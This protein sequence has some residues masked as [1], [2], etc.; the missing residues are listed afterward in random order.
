MLGFGRRSRL[1][2]R[3]VGPLATSP[4]SRGSL[5]FSRSTQNAVEDLFGNSV[6]LVFVNKPGLAVGIRAPQAEAI[7]ICLSRN[8]SRG[9]A[10]AYGL[11]L[12][13][14]C[15]MSEEVP[16]KRSPPRQDSKVVTFQSCDPPQAFWSL[17][18]QAIYLSAM[19]S[20]EFPPPSVGHLQTLHRWP[21]GWGGR[22]HDSG[23][24]HST[25]DF[26][27]CKDRVT[28][29]RLRTLEEWLCYKRSL[30]SHCAQS[31]AHFWV[32]RYQE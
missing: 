8:G 31:L 22:Y 1:G 18:I 7:P 28:S 14:C 32:I 2:R 26:L 27:L 17:S 23:I 24:R 12:T 9:L 11:S 29:P 20:S 5:G 16:S 15:L 13:K 19:T 25:T 10:S 4:F 6:L 30:N 3:V 21:R